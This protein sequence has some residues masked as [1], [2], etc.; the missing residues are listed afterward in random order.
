MVFAHGRD[1]SFLNLKFDYYDAIAHLIPGTI[2]CLFLLYAFDLV[3][4]VLPRPDVGSSL[5]ITGVG[6][7]VAYTAGHLVQSLASTFEPLYYALWGGKPSIKLLTR[8]SRYF[9]NEQRRRLVGD[10]IVFFK[11]SEECPKDHKGSQNFH[12]RLFERCMTLCN[13]SKLGRVETFNAIYAF[14]RVL[15]TTF[16]LGFLAYATI[17]GMH[18]FGAFNIPPTNLPLLKSLMLL[19]GLGTGIELFRAR[20]RAY[21]YAREVLWM[22]S[23]Y[24]RDFACQ[25][26]KTKKETRDPEVRGAAQT[27]DY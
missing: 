9:S 21:Y 4:I 3:G 17:W 12:Q 2:G 24:I 19:A 26:E 14:H 20:K 22:T 25:T 8:E 6:I 11:V 5:G 1:T 7:A 16:L 23:D 10:L 27:W 18:Y 15:L 13:R